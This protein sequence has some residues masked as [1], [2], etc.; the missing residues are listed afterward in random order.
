MKWDGSGWTKLTGLPTDD[1]TALAID[2]STSSGTLYVGTGEDGVFVSEDG[3]D[4]WTSFNQGLGNLSITKLA[5][6]DSLPKMLYAGTAYGGIWSEVLDCNGD[7][8]GDGEIT[9]EDALCAFETYLE[10]CPTS[11][12]IPC[13]EVCCDVTQHEDCTP[14][15]ALCIFQ[16]YLEVPSC[17]D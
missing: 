12:D 14:A 5:I 15:D 13:E 2:K 10:R 11:C 4:T 8:N 9:P 7:V 1:I 17:L 16:K 3:G 6:S